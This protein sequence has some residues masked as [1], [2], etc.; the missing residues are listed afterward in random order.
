MQ[1]SSSP[2]QFQKYSAASV[3]IALN[4]IDKNALD[5][6][7]RLHEAGYGAWL[8][9]GGVRD[10][11]MGEKPKD[12]DIATS[13][14]PD[15]VLPLFKR[16]RRIGRRFT[17]VH[18]LHRGPRSRQPPY[19]PP[20][21]EVATLR[22]RPKRVDAMGKILDDNRW[23]E[24]LEDDVV[25]RDFS[26]NALYLNPLN[27][28]LL[29]YTGG[30]EDMRSRRLVVVGEPVQ[31]FREDPVRILRLVRFRARYDFVI[32]QQE[33]AAVKACRETLKTVDTAR[34]LGEVEKMLLSGRGV[35]TA[36]E[37]ESL[38]L[39]EYLMPHW[40]QPVS[41]EP[42]QDAKKLFF[43]ALA[44]VDLQVQQGRKAH[45]STLVAAFLWPAYRAAAAS[46]R[47]HEECTAA[48]AQLLRQQMAQVSMYRAE[49]DKVI[50]AC[51][52]QA[53]WSKDRMPVGTL[54]SKA[55][56]LALR[57]AALRREAG[58]PQM[59]DFNYAEWRNRHHKARAEQPAPTGRS[60]R[61]GRRR[62]PAAGRD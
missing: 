50:G 10:L 34:M 33:L 49:Q 43:A 62:R 20:Y 8:V 21:S 48:A 7:E 29:D 41:R 18:V 16:S 12:F 45:W 6:I 9:G 42:G 4:D 58:E 22:G 28:E 11:L 35:K 27:G 61:A 5:I 24:R 13:A 15:Q 52:T 57:L 25:R 46:L 44:H 51:L 23:S 47:S 40:N 39:M 26:I 30:V 19:S 60:R 31:R 3:G 53:R 37:L 38:H 36:R 2:V 14:R 55:F 59:A 54:V 1:Q 32:G 56:P 17:I